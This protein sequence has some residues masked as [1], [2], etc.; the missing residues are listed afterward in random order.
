MDYTS[1]YGVD[2]HHKWKRQAGEEVTSSEAESDDDDASCPEDDH[3]WLWER[4]AILCFSDNKLKP[5]DI[6]KGYILLFIKSESDKLFNEIMNNVIDAEFRGLPI[7]SAVEYALNK[8]EESIIASV[9]R[10]KSE[11]SFWSELS[12]FG[13][14]W[15]C[16]WFTGEPCHC[17]EC[18]G[19]SI[20]KMTEVYIKLFISM[21]EDDL[22]EQIIETQ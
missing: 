4:L 2:N 1:K 13:G 12:E 14:E 15:D 7:Q 6:F 18:G 10:C 20:L 8:N 5:L 17:T 9:N 22:I 19:V 21:R 3:D 16:Q 11:E